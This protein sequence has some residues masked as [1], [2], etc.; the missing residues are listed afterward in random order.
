MQP[1]VLTESEV[2]PI[3]A[4]AARGAAN[5][6]ALDAINTYADGSLLEVRARVHGPATTCVSSKRSSGKASRCGD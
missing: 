5:S 1:A 2:A 3:R 4:N 6:N